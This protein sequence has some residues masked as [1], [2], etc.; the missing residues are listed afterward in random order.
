MIKAIGLGAGGHAKVILEILLLDRQLEIRGLLASLP[1]EVGATLCGVRV[2]GDDSMLPSLVQQ[3]VT[4]AF[5]GVGSTSKSD[6]RRALYD[7][8]TVLGLKMLT[9]I[10]PSAV[11]SPSATVGPGAAILAGVIVNASARIGA[12]AILNTGAIVEHDVVVGDHCHIAPG[13][14]VGGGVSI[15]AG[16]HIGIGAVVRHGQRIGS[17]VV[18]GAGAVV[19]SDIAD[20]VIVVGVPARPRAD[21]SRG[22]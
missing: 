22:A 20:H 21:A 2:I 12:N 11:I 19:V 1:S 18:V 17:G 4:H 14:I 16:S 9:A 5:M 7:R 8:A 6:A 3:G 13:A 10:H 15:G